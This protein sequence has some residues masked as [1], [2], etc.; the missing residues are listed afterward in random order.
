MSYFSNLDLAG[1]RPQDTYAYLMLTSASVV[2]DGAGNEFSASILNITAS[3]ADRLKNDSIISA[4]YVVLPTNTSDAN[5][6]IG[7]MTLQSYD[8]NNSWF[9]D[10]V[11]FDGTY[12]RRIKAGKAFMFYYFENSWQLRCHDDDVA[13]S[14]IDTSIGTP[15]NQI[16]VY[17]NGDVGIGGKTNF[18]I[19]KK[20]H[21]S[22]DI[23]VGKIHFVRVVFK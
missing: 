11:Y 20:E 22:K 23:R 13:E 8:L 21:N 3:Y 2:T 9:G 18:E 5:L 1:K 17:E 19:N 14:I 15:I 12:F 16:K 10:N 6:R 4:S 7:D